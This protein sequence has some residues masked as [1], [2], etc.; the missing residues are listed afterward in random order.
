MDKIIDF[1]KDIMKSLTAGIIITL[2]L[3]ALSG[4]S[5]F[6]F[7]NGDVLITLD[8]IKN[9]LFIIGGLGLLIV[10]GF[11]AK[12]EARRPLEN[13]SQWK[14]QFKIIHFVNVIGIVD[15]T[16]LC[17]GILIDSLIFYL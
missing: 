1:I 7:N 11:I 3:I 4:I 14:E 2:V 5:G 16:I 8:I 6:L 12:R 15:L 17:V 9:T 13:K 10:A